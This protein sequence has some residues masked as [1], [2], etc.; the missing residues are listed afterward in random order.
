MMLIHLYLQIGDVNLQN[1]LTDA[2]P[3]Y[4]WITLSMLNPVIKD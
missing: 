1:A 2:F 3:N 4:T